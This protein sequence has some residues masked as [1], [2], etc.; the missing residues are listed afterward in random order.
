MGKGR[1]RSERKGRDGNGNR[2]GGMGMGREGKG[3]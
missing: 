1:Q 2:K 3:E